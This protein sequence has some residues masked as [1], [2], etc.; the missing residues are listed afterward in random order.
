M[1]LGLEPREIVK[2]RF[3]G[4]DPRACESY[5][6]YTLAYDLGVENL[7]YGL[8]INDCMENDN[9]SNRDFREV[10]FEC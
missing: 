4:L 5:N 2:L 1:V 8:N 9:G 6:S 7:T 3:K 10:G